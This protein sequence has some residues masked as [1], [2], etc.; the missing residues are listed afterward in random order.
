[1]H[2]Y[3]EQSMAPRSVKVGSRLNKEAARCP[4]LLL[5][6]D[7]HTSLEAVKSDRYGGRRQSRLAA[8]SSPTANLFLTMAS[9]RV[10]RGECASKV[11]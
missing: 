4:S 5:P 9:L 8:G 6:R 11:G 2:C 3:D 7:G 1:M 10:V